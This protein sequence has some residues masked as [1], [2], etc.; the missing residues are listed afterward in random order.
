MEGGGI[1]DMDNN[2]CSED[3]MGRALHK[4]SKAQRLHDE[5]EHDSSIQ[6]QQFSR[7]SFLGN[8]GYDSLTMSL[9]HSMICIYN[10]ALCYQYK[11]M[12]AKERA[13]RI[14]AIE[15]ATLGPDK[16]TND[17]TLFRFYELD[18]L[19]TLSEYFL[20]ASVDHYTRAYE[21][22]TRFRLKNGAQYTLLM[23]T[24]NNLAATYQ[25]LEQSYK[26]DVCNRHLTKSLVHI[27]CS[28]ERDGHLGQ[29]VLSRTSFQDEEEK[30]TRCSGIL[31][32]EEHRRAFESFLSNVTHLMMG[33]DEIYRGEMTATAA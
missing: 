8:N 10:I 30:I 16:S 21:L 22:M 1:D 28:S 27:I 14:Q 18:R 4:H 20:K 11:G 23:A 2:I 7:D 6:Q 9:F 25:S 3:D 26:A 12:K 15:D 13:Q 33:G 32:R 24:M 31:S 29:E 17:H 5:L 19:V